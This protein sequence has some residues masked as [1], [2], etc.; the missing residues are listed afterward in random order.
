[1]SMNRIIAAVMAIV[2]VFGLMSCCGAPSASADAEPRTL[3]IGVWWDIFYDS[4]HESPEDDPAYSGKLNEI[5]HFDNVKKIEEEFNV[6]FEYVNLTFEGVKESVNTSILAG[7]PDCDIYLCDTQFGIPAAMGGL[8]LDMK[9][10]LPEDA[11]VLTDRAIVNYMD[12][13]DG[14]VILMTPTGAE[15]AV[16]NTWPLA[17]NVQMLEDY[18]LEDPRDLY[19]RG[20]WTWDKFVEYLQVLTQDT[21]GDGVVDQFGY[22]GFSKDTLKALL[23][24]NGA[25]IASGSTETLTSPA[26]GECLKFLSDLYNVYN[27][28]EPYVWESPWEVCRFRFSDGNVGFWPGAPWVFGENNCYDAAGTGD[29]TLEFDTA[30]VHW[31]VGPSG[32]KETNKG[33]V[34]QG[35]YYMIPVGV[36]DPELVYKV[37]EAICNWY[38]NDVEIRDDRENLEWWYSVHASDEDLQVENFE[39]MLDMGS[40]P[41]FDL[42][43]SC[44]VEMDMDALIRGDMTAAQMQESFRQEYQAALDAY[45]G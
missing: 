29:P 23:L 27:V 12:L 25:S 8:G 15:A 38:D 22:D 36:E 39:V 24:S 42:W 40:K 9:S 18:N 30:F 17:F 13:G 34:T 32:D 3:Y 37:F 7:T 35:N 33:V 45:F 21:D 6:R 5:M 4:T 10:V 41:Q 43:D 14:K 11:D 20:E 26:V 19:E 16:S 2:M 44:G 28:C 1:M 31:P